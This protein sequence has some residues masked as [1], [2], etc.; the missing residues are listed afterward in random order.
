[1]I[2]TN[3]LIPLPYTPDLSEAGI[4][5]A[6]RWLAGTF[7]RIGEAPA[8]RMRGEAGGAAVELAFRRHLSAQNVPFEVREGTP[9]RQPEHFNL[10]LGGHRCDVISY[11]ISRPNQLAQLRQDPANLLQAPALIPLDQFS[12]EGH[13]PDDLYVFAF[14][15]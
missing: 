5:C 4:A 13:K 2:S 12:A 1:M 14:L 9:F 3:D 11:L 7:E 8:E 10:A 15:V 6:C